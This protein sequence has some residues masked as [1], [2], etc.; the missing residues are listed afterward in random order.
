MK[1]LT[2]GFP[3]EILKDVPIRANQLLKFMQILDND[4]MLEPIV[5]NYVSDRKNHESSDMTIAD[6]EKSKKLDKALEGIKHLMP[7]GTVFDEESDKELK[8]I[9][10]AIAKGLDAEVMI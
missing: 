3:K 8:N 4:A 10:K 7:K 9:F 2:S 1:M 5:K 6:W